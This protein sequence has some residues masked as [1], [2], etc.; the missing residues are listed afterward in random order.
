MKITSITYKEYISNK[1]RQAGFL[2]TLVLFVFGAIS[3][4]PD[5]REGDEE[6]A[7]EVNTEL[8]STEWEAREGQSEWGDKNHEMVSS[9]PG[10]QFDAVDTDRDQRLTY[11]EFEAATREQEENY[12][13]NWDTDDDDRFSER[14]LNEGLFNNW[15]RNDDGVLDGAEYQA[16]N[17]AWGERQGDNFSTWDANQ[18]NQLDLD[19]FDRG[20]TEA[21]T[22]DAWDADEDG[23]FTRDELRRGTY[24]LRDTDRDGYLTTEEYEE[25]EYNIWGLNDL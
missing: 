19:E 14:E 15:D 13:N 10:A 18:D 3:C 24:G 4:S 12:F 20:Q 1:G 8:E 7:E 16:Y 11:E 23:Y 5:T 9:T 25:M 6:A 2:L 22:Y 17:T 21:G